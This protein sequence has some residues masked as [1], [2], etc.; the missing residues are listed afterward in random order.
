MLTWIGSWSAFPQF[1][2]KSLLLWQWQVLRITTFHLAIDKRK[3]GKDAQISCYFS[4]GISQWSYITKGAPCF[5]APNNQLQYS[6][7]DFPFI[8][9]TE[10]C[11]LWANNRVSQT[12]NRG[13]VQLFCRPLIFHPGYYPTASSFFQFLLS[14]ILGFQDSSR[15]LSSFLLSFW[16]FLFPFFLFFWGIELLFLAMWSCRFFSL[17]EIFRLLY[18]FQ[19]FFT[20]IK[21]PSWFFST[22]MGL[23]F[24]SYYLQHFDEIWKRKKDKYM[25]SVRK[26]QSEVFRLNFIPTFF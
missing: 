18:T 8:W 20:C 4:L 10:D 13:L 2:W 11:F 26:V 24:F 19:K 6:V 12:E 17:G 22:A 7:S 5:S 3:K 25:H 14:L 21:A 16:K 15:Q 23:F 9:P 1:K